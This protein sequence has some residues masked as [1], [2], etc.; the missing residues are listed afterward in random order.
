MGILIM[1]PTDDKPKK[2]PKKMDYSELASI[3]ID[4]K[5]FINE[6][7]YTTYDLS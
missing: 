5:N 3:A 1:G 4:A 2:K 6:T 7:K